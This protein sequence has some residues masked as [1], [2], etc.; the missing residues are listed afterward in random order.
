MQAREQQTGR[1]GGKSV[2][3]Q[4]YSILNGCDDDD[5]DLDDD[6]YRMGKMSVNDHDDY[7]SYDNRTQQGAKSVSFDPYSS[8]CSIN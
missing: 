5:D 1:G 2:R 8:G 4:S 3:I 7:Y 6:M